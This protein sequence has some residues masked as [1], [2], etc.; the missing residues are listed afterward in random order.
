MAAGTTVRRDTGAGTRIGPGAQSTVF[1][2]IPLVVQ[3]QANALVDPSDT[4]SGP[5]LRAVSDAAGNRALYLFDGTSWV[6]VQ[7][8]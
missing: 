3:T 6:G 1:Q 7:L 2:Y 4:P 5:Q 8:S